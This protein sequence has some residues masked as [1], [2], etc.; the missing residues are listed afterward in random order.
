[1]KRPL[2]GSHT[3]LLAFPSP[4]TSGSVPVPDS[5]GG[6]SDQDRQS[7]ENWQLSSWHLPPP[8]SLSTPAP[9][10]PQRLI[11]DITGFSAESGGVEFDA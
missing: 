11:E 10:L 8:A 1:M 9:S 2:P 3:V 6:R 7:K 4:L 5:G